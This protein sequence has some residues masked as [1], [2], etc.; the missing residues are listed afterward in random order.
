MT[1]KNDEIRASQS[2]ADRELIKL[3]NELE[4]TENR[5]DNANTELAQVSE[6]LVSTQ[7]S[8]KELQTLIAPD[9]EAVASWRITLVNNLGLV[10]TGI[11][12]LAVVVAVIAFFYEPSGANLNGVKRSGAR[13]LIEVLA[14]PAAAR[15]LITFL[16]VVGTIVMGLLLL[17]SSFR[18][19]TGAAESF[20]RGKEIFTILVGIL[21]TI[22]GFYFGVGSNENQDKPTTAPITTQQ[23]MSDETEQK[24]SGDDGGIEVDDDAKGADEDG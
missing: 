10:I 22:I 6:M 18:T 15:G 14:D 24:P 3:R 7:E 9:G 4:E 2:S 20:T 19:T 5:L 16:V 21:G 23:P 8:E 17:I 11:I 1:N 13:A 12:V